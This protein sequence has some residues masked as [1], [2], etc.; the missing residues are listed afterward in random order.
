MRYSIDVF[1]IP[2]NAYRESECSDDSPWRWMAC[3]HALVTPH[4]DAENKR[5]GYTRFQ[6]RRG[7]SPMRMYQWAYA[8]LES[9]AKEQQSLPSREKGTPNA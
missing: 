9:Y 2:V 8:L 3:V 4:D 5:Y 1:P 6:C 7:M